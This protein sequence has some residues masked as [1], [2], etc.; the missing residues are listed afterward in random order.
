MV[1]SSTKTPY[2]G[3]AQEIIHA[4]LKG[5][6]VRFQMAANKQFK[7]SMYHDKDTLAFVKLYLFERSMIRPLENYI[8]SSGLELLQLET[9]C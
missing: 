7:V 8:K 3:F 6:G 5:Y 4:H 9:K 2:F 1:P